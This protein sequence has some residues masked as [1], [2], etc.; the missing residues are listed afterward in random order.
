MIK[1]NKIVGFILLMISSYYLIK[2]TILKDVTKILA[3][4][5][6]PIMVMVPKLFKNKINEKLKF[7][8]YFYIFILLIL[9]CLANF[10]SIFKYY[11][12]FAH[13][14]FGFIASLMSLYLL[15][16]FKMDS[17]RIFNM[18]FIIAL[19]LALA[20]MW[21]IFEYVSS[22]IFNEDIQNVLTTGV[23]DTMEDIISS[24]VASII[25][26]VIYIFKKNK[27]DLLLK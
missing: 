27:L 7:I 14:M 10:Y 17:N 20:S 23:K 3:S 1:T 24:L 26:V 12:V 25:F 6:V 9:G 19:T 13:F 15:N 22:I 8:Y 11:D 18:T 4:L 16:L 2:F 21:E 5:C